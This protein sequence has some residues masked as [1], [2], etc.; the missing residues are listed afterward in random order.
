M[1][2]VSQMM[3]H[4]LYQFTPQ[5]EPAS[6]EEAYMDVSGCGHMGTPLQIAPNKFLAKMASDLKKPN[7][8]GLHKL[9]TF[10][11]YKRNS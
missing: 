4:I 3:L 11:S 9:V 1:V 2:E 6:I 7:A 8:I 10:P 5:I